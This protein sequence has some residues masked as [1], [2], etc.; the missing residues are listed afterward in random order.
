[1][2]S[3]VFTSI[4]VALFSSMSFAATQPSSITV[5]CEGMGAFHTIQVQKKVSFSQG[6]ASLQLMKTKTSTI[7]LEYA[8]QT[9]GPFRGSSL[10]TL[11]MN[12]LKADGTVETHSTSSR[13]SS[14]VIWAKDT[15]KSKNGELLAS[16]LI[17]CRVL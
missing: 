3:F 6:I 14:E 12:T 9:S 11:A 16:D 2:K 5:A 8:I 7:S 15:Y 10:F 17:S 4:L 13:Q 1:M